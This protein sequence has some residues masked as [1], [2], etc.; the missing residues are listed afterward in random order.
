MSLPN[1]TVCTI[2]V[3]I[4]NGIVTKVNQDIENDEVYSYR[5]SNFEDGLKPFKNAGVKVDYTPWKTEGFYDIAGS[6]FID[7]ESLNNAIKNNKIK[8]ISDPDDDGWLVLD[9]N[10]NE[11][12]DPKKENRGAKLNTLHQAEEL[13][14]KYSIEKIKSNPEL[15]TQLVNLNKLCSELVETENTDFK[16]IVDLSA[17]IRGLIFDIQEKYPI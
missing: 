13:L 4:E 12:P 14:N 1:F 9:L 16:Q 3:D 5:E 17:D 8:I 11:N 2:N 15:K 6:F 7:A 10:L